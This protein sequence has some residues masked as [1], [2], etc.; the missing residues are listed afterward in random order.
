MKNDWEVIQLEQ[1]EQQRRRQKDMNL[2]YIRYFVKLAELKHYTKAAEALCISQPSLS[3]AVRQLENELGVQLFERKGRHTVLTRFGAEFLDTSRRT[4]ST[5]DTGIS[6]LKRSAAGEGTI[7]LGLLRVL[8]VNFV[9]RLAMEFIEKNPGKDIRFTFHT[10]RTEALLDK[11]S[12]GGFDLVFCS[13]PRPEQSMKAT[14]VL[15]QKLVVI[16]PK[17]HP[18]AER[19]KVGL[20]ETLPYPQIYFAAGSGIRDVIDGLFAD[21]GGEPYIISETEEDQVIAGLVAAGFGIAVVPEMEILTNLDVAV[22]EIEYPPYK[23]EFF[24]VENAEVYLAPAAS[25][26][27][28]FVV[29]SLG[30]V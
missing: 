30:S 2:E 7:R 17:G 28:D 21:I 14:P 29:Q 8:G 18:M 9:P 27:R 15:S 19:K 22:L 26:F 1:W 3:N 24:M 10:E 5:L 25:S 4:L 11:L 23:R 16:V 20:A 13:A 6:S 12:E